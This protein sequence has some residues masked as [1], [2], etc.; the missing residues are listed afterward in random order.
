MIDFDKIFSGDFGG[1]KTGDVLGL[2][3]GAAGL[4]GGF[5]RAE[6]AAQ[7]GAAQAQAYNQNAL[8]Q[9]ENAARARLTTA[10]NQQYADY[11]K[12]QLVGKQRAAYG[13]A[14]VGIDSGSPLDVM[15]DTETEARFEAFNRWY[16]GEEEAKNA[17]AAAYFDTENAKAA[18]KAAKTSETSDILGGIGTVASIAAKIFLP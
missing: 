18:K 8:V 3:A 14:G 15:F 6:G 2:G 12:N 9:G 4:A 10:R 1:I 17:G 5:I 13:A 7:T 11:Q 16:A